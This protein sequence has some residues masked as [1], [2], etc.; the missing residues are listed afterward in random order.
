MR[1]IIVRAL[2]LLGALCCTSG[3]SL[4]LARARKTAL[5]SLAGVGPAD[6]SPESAN[7]SLVSSQRLVATDHEDANR[8]DGHGLDRTGAHG[9]ALVSE[10]LRMD[11]ADPGGDGPCKGGAF[12]AC[13]DGTGW[14]ASPA[15]SGVPGTWDAVLLSTGLEQICAEEGA[16]TAALGTGCAKLPGMCQARELLLQRKCTTSAELRAIRSGDVVFL[17]ALSGMYFDAGGSQIRARWPDQAL[18]ETF[19]VEA[20]AEGPLTSGDQLRLKTHDGSYVSHDGLNVTAV[21]NETRRLTVERDGG[22][23]ILSGNAVYLKFHS[24]KFIG[25]EGESVEAHEAKPGSRQVLHIEKEMNW[26]NATALNFGGACEKPGPS[27]REVRSGSAIFLRAGTGKLIDVV[28]EKV[29]ARWKDYGGWQKLTLERD[30]GSDITSGDAVFLKTHEGTHIDVEGDSVQ[31]RVN[32]HGA[33]QELR[34]EKRGGGAI[35]FGDKVR[36]VTRDGKNITVR[37]ESVHALSEADS[38]AQHFTVEKGKRKDTLNFLHIPKNA[39]TAIEDA[40]MVEGIRWGRLAMPDV[41]KMENDD[42]CPAHSAPP[43]SLPTAAQEKYMNLENVCVTRHPYDRAFS[44]YLYRLYMMGH[45]NRTRDQGELLKFEQCSEQGL[46]H[47]LQTQLRRQLDGA[48]R[49]AL[50][51]HFVPQSSYIWDQDRQWCAHILRMEDLPGA[52]NEL[53]EEKGYPVRLGEDVHNKTNSHHDF[54]PH[55]SVGSLNNDTKSLLNAVYA[56]DFRRLGYSVG[57]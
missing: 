2:L 57:K 11:A 8:T 41:V 45:E 42:S 7:V 14:R 35:R 12:D 48:G 43:A 24:G 13:W 46:N 27:P 16:A 1:S 36:L 20:D 44:D 5:W 52:F 56:T 39:G 19:V 49:F 38:E 29:Q 55:L 40:A 50:A 6:K 53:M 37:N 47:F 22:G 9:H 21:R 33:M 4:T 18:W 26:Q 15:C 17:R 31:A 10:Q 3:L 51:C 54:C 28:D 34:L 25:I 30:G 23:E 32:G